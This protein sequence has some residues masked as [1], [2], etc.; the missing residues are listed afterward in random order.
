MSPRPGTGLVHPALIGQA[1]ALAGTARPSLGQIQEPVRVNAS[2]GQTTT[3]TD[4]GDP[5]PVRIAPVTA[6]SRSEREIA[7]RMEA[8]KPVVL[9][10]DAG[11]DISAKQRVVVGD[12]TFEVLEVF[13]PHDYEVERRVLATE[14]G[15]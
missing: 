2:S 13:G 12:R 3:W 8:T 7:D 9:A 1:G 11:T 5:V 15:Q 4:V 6:L 10:F 14:R